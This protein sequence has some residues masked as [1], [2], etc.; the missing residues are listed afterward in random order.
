MG[1]QMIHQ[2]F[3]SRIKLFL[4]GISLVILFVISMTSCKA[5]NEPTTGG[6]TTDSLNNFTVNGTIFDA[7]TNS[8]LD[9]VSVLINYTVGK[10]TVLSN[11]QGIYA[12]SFRLD[13]NRTISLTISKSG[14]VS[15]TTTFF[16]LTGRIYNL[17]AIKL[18]KTGVTPGGTGSGYASSIYLLSQS[19]ASLGV[20]GSGSLETGR[21]TF[22]V[23]DSL[24]IPVD[25]NHKVRVNFKFG[26]RP[27][28]GEYLNTPSEN[29]DSAGTA[30]VYLTSG[31]RA[32]VVQIVADFTIN[33]KRIFSQPVNY[34]IHGGLPALTHF[35][36]APAKLNFP[37]YNINGLENG[38]TAILG[39]K[40]ANPVRPGT[41]TYFTTDGGIIQGSALTNELGFATALLISSD[42]RPTHPILGPGFATVTTSTIDE[43]NLIIEKKILVLFSGIAN[44]VSISPS[45]FNVLNNGSQS[46]DYVV[47]D[48]NNNP[49]AGGQSIKVTTEGEGV[50]L[51]GDVDITLPDTQSRAWT[52]FSFSLADKDTANVARSVGIR[53]ETTGPNGNA[54]LSI[55]GTVR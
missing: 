15:D 13:T 50:E 18:R 34:S 12:A 35:G 20:R 39:D 25:L 28:G 3:T 48:Q 24:G 53:I 17:S 22:R 42:P 33:G 26:G 10:K 55:S 5:P 11:S 37:G 47:S 32:G 2:G 38:I 1:N 9:S 54:A 23:L 51:R 30:S 46:F 16:A 45:T 7:G 43:S 52:F 49:L 8:P 27:N 36:L 44:V 14:Y 19:S 4:S 21:I 29:T 41:S 40:Y 31:T 6:G